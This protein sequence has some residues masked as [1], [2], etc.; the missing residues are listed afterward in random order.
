M[1]LTK[2]LNNKN[3]KYNT[4]QTDIVFMGKIKVVKT[5]CFKDSFPITTTHL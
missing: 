4:Q 3:N 2:S 5:N 1:L